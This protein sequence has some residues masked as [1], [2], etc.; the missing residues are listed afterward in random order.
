MIKNQRERKSTSSH[1][2][3][4]SVNTHKKTTQHTLLTG[5]QTL[6]L[7]LAKIFP[8]MIERE[9]GDDVTEHTNYYT[10]STISTHIY[11]RERVRWEEGKKEI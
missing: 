9:Q 6:W 1:Q 2:I 4:V 10:S 11:Y 5:T 7:W 3:V 8:D